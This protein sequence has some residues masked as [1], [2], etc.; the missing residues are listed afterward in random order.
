MKPDTD[1]TINIAKANTIT[2]ITKNDNITRSTNVDNVT[3][4]MASENTEMVNP[5]TAAATSSAATAIANKQ[6][7]I[8]TDTLSVANVETTSHMTEH[9]N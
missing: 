4:N 5:M 1:D 9:A 8:T 6:M 7:K 3:A 2:Q